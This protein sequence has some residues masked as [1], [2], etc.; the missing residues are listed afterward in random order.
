MT[1]RL[2]LRVTEA[3]DAIGVSRAKAYELIAAGELPSV[4]LGGS[5]RV[6]VV[7]LQAWIER[8]LAAAVDAQP[9]SER[10]RRD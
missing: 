6:P 8:K 10:G 2:M 1:E 5:V 7:A 4:R 9:K 3:A